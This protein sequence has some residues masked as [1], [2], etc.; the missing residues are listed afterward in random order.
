MFKNLEQNNLSKMARRISTVY[1]TIII[2]FMSQ[3]SFGQNSSAGIITIDQQATF[4]LKKYKNL[5]PRNII[6]QC[7][8][9]T[10]KT[11]KKDTMYTQLPKPYNK[12]PIVTYRFTNLN[13]LERQQL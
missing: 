8:A 3:K 12:S 13:R 9:M 11:I 10:S 6:G 4:V 7:F 2:F 1:Y 5:Q